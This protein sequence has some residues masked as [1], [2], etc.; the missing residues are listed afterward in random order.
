VPRKERK[1]DTEPEELPKGVAPTII[2]EHKLHTHGVFNKPLRALLTSNP[3]IVR[4]ITFT[5]EKCKGRDGFSMPHDKCC[6]LLVTRAE[7]RH[8]PW[9]DKKIWEIQ[10]D[11][12][13][14]SKEY[15][16]EHR[17]NATT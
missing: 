10:S 17:A 2:R 1:M 15:E 16:A 8:W 12:E 13:K 14:Y 7:E 11:M 4:G 9:I 6:T 3:V 5:E